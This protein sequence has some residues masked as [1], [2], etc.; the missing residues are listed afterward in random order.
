MTIDVL[1]SGKY[2]VR[3][4]VNGKRT[5]KTFDHEPTKKEIKELLTDRILDSTNLPELTLEKAFK[6]YISDKSDIL[7]PTTIS[8]YIPAFDRLSP[9]IKIKKLKDIDSTL[10]QREIN[11]LAKTYSWKSLKH[12][13]SIVKAVLRYFDPN[14]T[15]RVTLPKKPKSEPYI[16]KEHEIQAILNEVKG[17]RYDIPIKLACYGLRV[18]EICALTPQDITLT[19]NG[20][21]V[22]VS[23]AKLKARNGKW[24]VKLP[25]TTES[26]RTVPI[27]RDLA[28]QILEEGR[29]YDGYP[30]SISNHLY[31]IE[32]RLGL[33]RF[34]IHKFRHY[35]CSKCIDLG[36]DF[37][38]IKKLGGWTSLQTIENIYAHVMNQDKKNA[39][40]TNAIG[41]VINLG[42]EQI[43]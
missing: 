8:G 4:S 24:V 23:K 12:S 25:K 10:L 11:T 40:I 5:S 20:A 2:R 32:D 41:S 18:G 42:H 21:S 9:I 7:S 37:M 33:E 22:T 13:V 30:T 36:I 16:P 35:F 34:S 3:L 17:T 38:T 19:P 14:V 27:D 39:T 6:V 29:V 26:N 43:F 1:P 31:T 28:E 15:I